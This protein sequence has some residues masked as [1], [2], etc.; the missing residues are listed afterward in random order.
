MSGMRMF[1]R[2]KLLLTVHPQELQ[3]T[4]TREPKGTPHRERSTKRPATEGADDHT[5]LPSCGL[6][7]HPARRR[8][9]LSQ[10]SVRIVRATVGEP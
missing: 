6:L 8:F 10:A 2:S 1:R 7:S 3:T 9:L 5:E 4:T